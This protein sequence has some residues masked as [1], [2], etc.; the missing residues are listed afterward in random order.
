MT[1]DRHADDELEDST[2]RRRLLWAVGAL[3]LVAIA[4]AGW[5]GFRAQEAKSHLEQ[6]RAS[7]SMD[8]SLIANERHTSAPSR[9]VMTV[10]IVIRSSTV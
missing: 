5:L 9:S 6:A 2:S 1:D 4:F 3:L 8:T 10:S 7:F